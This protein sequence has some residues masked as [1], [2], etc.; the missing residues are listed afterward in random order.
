MIFLLQTDPLT[1]EV[2]Y[3]WWR[4][5]AGIGNLFKCV[6][7]KD[8]IIIIIIMKYSSQECNFMIEPFPKMSKALGVIFNI[9]IN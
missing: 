2:S 8:I 6:E 4:S 5:S 3:L 7:M 9:V 1:S